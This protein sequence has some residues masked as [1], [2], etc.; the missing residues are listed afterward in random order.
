MSR[1]SLH[2]AIHRALAVPAITAAAGMALRCIAG[3][4]TAQNASKQTPETLQTTWSRAD[5]SA[6]S[7]SRRPTP[8]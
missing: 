3:S 2:F 1:T 4:A 8:W 7:T 5:T 6:G